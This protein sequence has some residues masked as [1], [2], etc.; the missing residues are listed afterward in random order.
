MN[1]INQ[2]KFHFQNAVQTLLSLAD[3]TCLNTLPD[4]I[5]FI[6]CYSLRSPLLHSEDRVFYE[7]KCLQKKGFL[8]L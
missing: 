8:Q 2:I 6:K 4:K 3:E 1:S 7:L 5:V